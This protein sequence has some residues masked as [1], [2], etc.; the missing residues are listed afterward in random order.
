[1]KRITIIAV[2]LF[3]FLISFAHAGSSSPVEASRLYFK[4]YISMDSRIYQYVCS[5]GVGP[6]KQLF[7]QRRQSGEQPVNANAA[8]RNYDF[9]L[10]QQSGNTAIVKTIQ[11]NPYQEFG[12]RLIKINGEWKV[13]N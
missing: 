4:Y 6:L 2:L 3:T 1:M 12:S 11:R 13:C 9:R 8:M 7:A 5:D 10:V